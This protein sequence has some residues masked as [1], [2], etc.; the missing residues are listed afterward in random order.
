MRGVLGMHA[1]FRF[2]SCDRAKEAY[3]RQGITD[4][5]LERVKT[6]DGMCVWRRR[7]ESHFL[8]FGSKRARKE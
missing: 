5:L 3:I 7:A 1:G 2:G 8:D 4:C 6:A